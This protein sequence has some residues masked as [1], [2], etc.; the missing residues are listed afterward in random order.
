MILKN[1]YRYGEKPDVDDRHPLVKTLS[2]PSS[3]LH[4]H[5]LEI[6]VQAITPNDEMPGARST[7][8]LV[9]A[10]E[11]AGSFGPATLTYPVHKSLVYAKSFEDAASTPIG[12][13]PTTEQEGIMVKGVIDGSWNSLQPGIGQSTTISP[14]NL[15]LGEIAIETFRKSLELSINYEHAW[16]D[17][18]M[19]I[20]SAWLS[21]GTEVQPGALKPSL[22]RLTETVIFN[23]DNAI[24]AE[25]ESK[26]QEA[27]GATISTSTRD[28][29]DQG[30]S[31]WAE[32]AHTELRDRL[33]SAFVS[34]SW[35]KLKWWKLLWR[36]DDVGLI[37]SDIL[38]RGWL[39]EAERDM[40]WLSGRIY[41]S[42]LIGPPKKRPPPIVDPEDPVNARLGARP[43]APSVSDL[44]EKEIPSFESQDPSH[45]SHPYPQEISL[46]RSSLSK[47]TIPPLQSL[48][49][50]LLLQTLSTTALTSSLS[51]LL[52][53]SISTTSV[54]EAGT[55]AAVGL[56][57]SLRR[58]QKRW[59]T[60]RARWEVTL[61]EQ[62]RRVLGLVEAQARDVARDG[63]MGKMD[64][65]GIEERRIAKESVGR[66]RDALAGV[67]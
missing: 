48:S 3:I 61:R 13:A 11:T 24:E 26:L 35:R 66:V 10:L 39:V 37:A 60:A 27:K 54:Y 63:G 59:E 5:N 50:T 40:I 21:E 64:E 55:I 62:G 28:I 53:I 31:I 29:I 25:K 22:R 57:W 67:S 36:V 4:T 9:P 42:G 14:I 1:M 49:Q 44:V 20:V 12:T 15:S 2:V 33:D 56:A 43:F 51:A 41:E 38:Q 16:F 58:L 6:F 30:I 65:M 23:T 19:P 52:Y 34:E 32:D 8:F 47:I 7:G 18:G 45:T 46:A 17:S